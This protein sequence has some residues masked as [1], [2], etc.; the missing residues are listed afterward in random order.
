MI[1]WAMQLILGLCV[2]TNACARNLTASK[3]PA[4]NDQGDHAE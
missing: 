4:D 2:S 1:D 3:Q